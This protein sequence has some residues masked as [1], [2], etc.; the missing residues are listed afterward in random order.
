M[1]TQ[2]KG[3]WIIGKQSYKQM[4]VDHSATVET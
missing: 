1:H 4:I 3:F 2:F